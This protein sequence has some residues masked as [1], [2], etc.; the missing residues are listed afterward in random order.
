MKVFEGVLQTCSDQFGQG[1]TA[2]GFERRKYA[3]AMGVRKHHL[4]LGRV[5]MNS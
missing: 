4:A 1:T 3:F 5:W 2:L